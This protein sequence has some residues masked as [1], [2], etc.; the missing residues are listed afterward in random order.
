M[1]GDSHSL[2]PSTKRNRNRQHNPP[3]KK[4]QWKHFNDLASDVKAKMLTLKMI[5]RTMAK[6]SHEVQTHCGNVAS[7]VYLRGFSLVDR[8]PSLS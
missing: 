4:S 8:S 2:G 6:V 7:G 1:L 3:N 5:S